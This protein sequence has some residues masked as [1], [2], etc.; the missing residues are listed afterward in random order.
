MMRLLGGSGVLYAAAAPGFDINQILA[1]LGG[2]AGLAAGWKI[3]GLIVDKVVPS[4][5][6]KRNDVE[7]SLGALAKTIEILSAEKASDAAA[8]ARA[9]TRIADLETKNTSN[10]DLIQVLK[11]SKDDLERRMLAKDE[12]IAQLAAKL[13]EYGAKVVFDGS[14]RLHIDTTRVHTGPINLPRSV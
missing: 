11:E 2:G 10:Y 6:D 14:G 9:N 8:V 3:I 1:L 12:H 7:T 13:A 5:S 4:R